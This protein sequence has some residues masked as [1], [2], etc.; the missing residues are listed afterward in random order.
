M[1]SRTRGDAGFIPSG[2]IP[3]LVTPLDDVGELDE[4]GFI[5]LVGSVIDAGV[6]AVSVLGSTGEVA[7]LPRSL[8]RHIVQAALRAADGRVPV[9]AGSPGGAICDAADEAREFL[10]FGAAA[11]LALPPSYFVLD[12]E[13]VVT[14]YREFA[15]RVR[16][17]IIVYHFPALTKVTLDPPTVARLAAIEGI[18]ALKDGSADE[19]FFRATA[20]L[21]R[22]DGFSLLAGS[23]RMATF[24]AGLGAK[25]MIA[26]SAN[27]I[28]AQLVQLW[29]ALVSGTSDE[30]EGLQASVTAIEN[31]CRRYPYPAN[32]K[33]AARLFGIDCGRPIV[34]LQELSADQLAT[35]ARTL[36]EL[37]IPPRGESSRLQVM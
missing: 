32:W 29:A 14:Y 9:I 8:R 21:T 20:A 17:P 30:V 34:P 27:V 26:A 4:Q 2:V 1:E 35:L 22:D 13:A 31:A 10:S 19:Q 7:L 24:A 23:G 18:V 12:Q 25:G 11:I 15:S 5:R 37:A 28:P 6:T 33:A 16:G 3:A 36:A